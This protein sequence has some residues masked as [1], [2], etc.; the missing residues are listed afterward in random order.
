MAAFDEIYDYVEKDTFKKYFRLA[1]VIFAYLIFRKLY[2]QWASK[3]QTDYQ[4]RLDAQEKKLKAERDEKE[5]L[6]AENKLNKEASEFGWG[7]KTRKN[8]KVTELVLE[9]MAQ[10]TRQRHQTSYDA[11]EDADIDDLLED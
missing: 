6:E 8:V 9:Q 5:R 2:S 11:Q 4:L 10:E 3:K 1:V 7:K